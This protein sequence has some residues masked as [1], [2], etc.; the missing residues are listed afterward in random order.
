MGYLEANSLRL[1]KLLDVHFSSTARRIFPAAR[2]FHPSPRTSPGNGKSNCSFPFFISARCA[3]RNRKQDGCIVQPP[4]HAARV[5]VKRKITFPTRLEH[6]FFFFF[7]N[8][9][10][11][12]SSYL[13]AYTWLEKYGRHSSSAFHPAKTKSRKRE[14]RSSDEQRHPLHIY[15]NY[16]TERQCDN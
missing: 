3:I 14:S 1:V 6:S 4:V 5:Y 16:I 15:Q 12:N 8:G 2:R 7:R 10:Q 11:R 13:Y 9:Q